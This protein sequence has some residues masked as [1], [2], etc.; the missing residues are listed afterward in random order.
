MVK[1][2]S[3]SV[4]K[5]DKKEIVPSLL[6]QPVKSTINGSVL[7]STQTGTQVPDGVTALKHQTSMVVGSTFPSVTIDQDGPAS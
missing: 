3:I 2:F 1:R 5:L 7:G 6:V 4:G